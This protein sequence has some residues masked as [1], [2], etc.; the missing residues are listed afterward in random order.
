MLRPLTK[1][2][3]RIAAHMA[4]AWG[5]RVNYLSVATLIAAQITAPVH[6]TDILQALTMMATF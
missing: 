4:T 5:G 2:T 1:V 3:A 6:A